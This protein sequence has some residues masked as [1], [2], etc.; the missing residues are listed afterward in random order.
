MRTYK[1]RRFV[2]FTAQTVKAR[3]RVTCSSL[4]VVRHTTRQPRCRCAAL[5]PCVSRVCGSSSFA[6]LYRGPKLWSYKWCGWLRHMLILLGACDHLQHVILSYVWNNVGIIRWQICPCMHTRASSHSTSAP[7]RLWQLQHNDMQKKF[8]RP[9]Q[10]MQILMGARDDPWVRN[11]L[12]H[13]PNSFAEAR[14]SAATDAKLR[15][16]STTPVT[17]ISLKMLYSCCN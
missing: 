7:Y 3:S 11:M 2:C 5:Q 16:R 1:L 6:A 15:P 17:Y 10:N 13:F 14:K 8:L 9:I 12:F 4:T